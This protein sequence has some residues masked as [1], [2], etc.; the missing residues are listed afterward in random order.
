MILLGKN[1]GYVAGR[2]EQVRIT[3]DEPLIRDSHASTKEL[4]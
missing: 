4:L 3:T 2:G 1:D